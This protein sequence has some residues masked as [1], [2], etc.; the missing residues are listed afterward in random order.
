MTRRILTT[1]AG[2]VLTLLLDGALSAQT[3]QGGGI[4]G[5]PSWSWAS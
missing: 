3:H 4:V 1:A 5:T 2:I